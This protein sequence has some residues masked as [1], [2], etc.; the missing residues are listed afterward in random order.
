M[1]K[2]L[3]TLIA[4]L[5]LSIGANAQTRVSSQQREYSQ[6]SWGSA[7][8]N[9]ATVTANGRKIGTITAT[10]NA[11]MSIT[12]KNNTNSTL[13]IWVDFC[14]YDSSDNKF[15]YSED[16]GSANGYK[17]DTV[18]ANGT[19]TISTSYGECKW[20]RAIMPKRIKLL[21]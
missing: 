11:N 2:I 16:S 14:A 1:K 18:S 7:G 21:K 20:V 15:D 6:V 12:V 3:F 4:L 10:T 5:S 19:F 9:V 8:Y 13:K 17:W